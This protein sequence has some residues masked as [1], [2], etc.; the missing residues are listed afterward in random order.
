[1]LVV[2]IC[3]H[4]LYSRPVIVGEEDSV[5][6]VPRGNHRDLLLT[7]DGQLGYE[8]LS[9]DRIEISLSRSRKI[10]VIELSSRSYFDL[11]E[12]KLRWGQGIVS[13]EKE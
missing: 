8:V 1:M 13:F 10:D 4:T 3:A 6:L 9:G 2:P 11:L 7:Q 5:T 12:E